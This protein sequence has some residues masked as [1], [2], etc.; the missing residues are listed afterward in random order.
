MKGFKGL[1]PN[2]FLSKNPLAM[3]SF[4]CYAETPFAAGS[5]EACG[6]PSASGHHFNQQPNL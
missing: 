2:C 4:L 6:T 5:G 3:V 1:L